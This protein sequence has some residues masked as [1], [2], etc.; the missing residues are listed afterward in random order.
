[1]TLVHMVERVNPL[2]RDM[3]VGT[4]FSEEGVYV[5]GYWWVHEMLFVIKRSLILVNLNPIL[6]YF[7]DKCKLRC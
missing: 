3:K 2:N 5:R 4:T 7:I 6:V 1:M